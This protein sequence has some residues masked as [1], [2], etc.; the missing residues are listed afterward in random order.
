MIRLRPASVIAALSLVACST[1]ADA[2]GAWVLW[3]RIADVT[4]DDRWLDWTN[5]GTAFPTYEKCRDKMRQY[6]R[7]PEENSLA[8]W[9]DWARGTGRH[10]KQGGVS[11]T[12][13]GVL[14]VSPQN[15]R[16]ASEWRCL[17]DT[18]DPRGPK[19]K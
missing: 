5:G 19:G 15:P 1:M 17:P 12:E 10:N 16:V 8:D 18:M 14:L 13:S 7:V 4:K 2:E 11:V 3:S 9:F 6:T